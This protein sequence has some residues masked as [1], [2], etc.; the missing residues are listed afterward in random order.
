MTDDAVIHMSSSKPYLIRALYEWI[1]DNNLTPHILVNADIPGV[2]VPSE[3]I[4]TGRIIL[5]ISPSAVRDLQLGNEW[6]DFHASFSQKT[7][8][9][10]IPLI[11]II[12]LYARENGRGMV[13]DASTEETISPDSSPPAGDS[14]QVKGKPPTLFVVK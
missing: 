4:E 14:P 7:T 8:R 9:I 13:F 6:I 10:L 12:A 3:A 2:R 1:V 11:A 5:N